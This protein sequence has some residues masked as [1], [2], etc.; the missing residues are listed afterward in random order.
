MPKFDSSKKDLE[1]LCGTQFSI[2]ELESALEYAKCELDGHENDALKIECK[3]TLRPE[4][5][6]VL[7]QDSRKTGKIPRIPK[8]VNKIFKSI[9]SS[10]VH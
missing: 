5:I 9:S 3:E 8:K 1:I 6:K 10:R 4:L 7:S 2:T